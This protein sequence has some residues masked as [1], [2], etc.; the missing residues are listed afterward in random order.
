MSTSN[1]L[2][3]APGPKARVRHRILAGIGALIVLAIAALVIKTLAGKGQFEASK[4]K[5]F[6]TAE[7]W[8]A[9][10]L[11]GLVG[12]LKAAAL[13]IV[14]SAVVGPALALARMSGM[15]WLRAIATVWVEIFRA[16]PVLLM[17]IFFFGVYAY[18]GVF[19]A[20]INPL[21][22]TVTGLVL[23]NSA[24]LCEV[25]RS[26]VDQIPRGQRE[27]G[28]SVGLSPAQTLRIVLL[29]QA[30]TAMLPTLVSQLVV[31]LKDT[32][33]GYNITYLE[34]LNAGNTAASNYGNLVPMIFVIALIFIAI[35]Y[36]LTKFAEYLERR[37]KRRGHTTGKPTTE[38]AVAE[39]A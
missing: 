14:I 9:Y 5:P 30:V 38:G 32:A 4:W 7:L 18:N 36:S 10:L 11:P 27:A 16:I 6:T 33:L 22:A 3:D 25:L 17:M 24:V 34:L 8:D 35:N 2:F 21:A 26:G 20:S 19:D 12:T 29:P 13:A 39:P 28:L 15:R 31:I 37:L 23:Y 1:V